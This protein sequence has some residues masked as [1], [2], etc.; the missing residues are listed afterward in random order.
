MKKTIGRITSILVLTV[1]LALLIASCQKDRT[2]HHGDYPD[3]A[4]SIFANSKCARSMP[5][6]LQVPAGNKLSLFSYGKGVQIYQVQRSSTDKNVFVWVNTAPDATIFARENF[7]KQLALHYAG[8]T[9]EFT[10][11]FLKGDKVV[12]SRLQGATKDVTAIP[13]LLLKTVDSLSVNNKITY[14]QRLCTE[15]GLA[16]TTG[17]DE[18]HL[19]QVVS[20]PYTAAYLFYVADKY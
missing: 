15:G 8:P 18:N 4:D 6:I 2:P 9:W 10:D 12:A 17:A 19:G 7:T 14:I 5:V 13:W 20:I 1:T 11:G 16:P 3:N